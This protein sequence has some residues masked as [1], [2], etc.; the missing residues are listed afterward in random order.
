VQQVTKIDLVTN[1]CMSSFD[2]R[3]PERLVG[4]RKFDTSEPLPRRTEMGK[5]II[6][7]FRCL[8]DERHRCDRRV[9]RRWRVA[10]VNPRPST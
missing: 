1:L 6:A 10:S 7:G 2:G 4:L 9:V 8:Y 3:I 5:A